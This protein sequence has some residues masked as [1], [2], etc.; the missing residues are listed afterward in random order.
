M[1]VTWFTSDT[2]IGHKGILSGRMDR[3]RPFPTIEAHDEYIVAMWNNRVRDEDIVWH[4]GDFAYGGGHTYARSVFDRLRGRKH[5]IV[6]NHEGQGLRLPWAAPPVQACRVTVQDPGMSRPVGCWLSHYS[7]R[8]WPNV[9][10]GDLH[11]Y[12]HSHG[13]LPGTARSCDVGVD[14]WGFRPV[15][16]SEVMEVLDEQAAREAGAAA[17]AALAEAA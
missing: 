8:T 5:L 6:G 4:L 9:W 16:L 13:A 14:C 1:A 17:A 15:R 12:G 2:H 7:H 3:P 10:R 11:L